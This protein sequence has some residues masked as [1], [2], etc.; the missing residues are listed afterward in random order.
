MTLGQ[1]SFDSG[2]HLFADFLSRES[3]FKDMTNH[4]CWLVESVDSVFME[5]SAYYKRLKDSQISALAMVLK[6][7][8]TSCS[9]PLQ[10]PRGGSS[11]P[12]WGRQKL[13]L[14]IWLCRVDTSKL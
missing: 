7:I 8:P 4:E 3:A 10:T 9:S 2:T 1:Y 12:W 11:H 14:D 13:Y 5:K 6:A